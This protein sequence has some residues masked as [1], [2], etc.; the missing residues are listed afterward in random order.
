MNNFYCFWSAFVRDW[1]P[2][3]VKRQEKTWKRLGDQIAASNFGRTSCFDRRQRSVIRRKFCQ[4]VSLSFWRLLW[5]SPVLQDFLLTST[6][7]EKALDAPKR[8]CLSLTFG[9]VFHTASVAGT[10]PLFRNTNL[11]TASNSISARERGARV[12]E[13]GKPESAWKFREF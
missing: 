2:C 6:F 3:A 5:S 9:L 4:R 7:P 12:W 11:R 10:K 8:Q 1:S 13:G